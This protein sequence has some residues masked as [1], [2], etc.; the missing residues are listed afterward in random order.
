MSGI[1]T[2]FLVKCITVTEKNS[3]LN[4]LLQVTKLKYANV[5]LLVTLIERNGRYNHIY[6]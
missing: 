5:T 1:Q 3:W 2:F 4:L 6:D